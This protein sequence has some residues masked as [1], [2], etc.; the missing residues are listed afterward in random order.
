M[1]TLD[2]NEYELVLGNIPLI[3]LHRGIKFI[4]LDY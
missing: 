3:S 4:L 2:D 1:L